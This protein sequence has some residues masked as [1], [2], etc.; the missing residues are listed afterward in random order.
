MTPRA[1]TGFGIVSALGI[2]REAFFEGMRE[3]PPQPA[4]T[5]SI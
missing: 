2:G 4:S 3:P 1:I 5:Q